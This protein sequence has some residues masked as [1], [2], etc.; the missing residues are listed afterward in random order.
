M[1]WLTC[2]WVSL[3][4]CIKPWNHILI[5]SIFPQS[6]LIFNCPFVIPKLDRDRSSPLLGVTFIN[7]NN[8]DP[9]QSWN[10]GHRT[11]RGKKALRIRFNGTHRVWQK[12][13]WVWSKFASNGWDLNY[14]SKRVLDELQNYYWYFEFIERLISQGKQHDFSLRWMNLKGRGRGKKCYKMSLF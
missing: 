1:G 8:F 13:V 9:H 14:S 11:V 3:T 4:A 5:T 7:P 10:I 6:C 2:D 12:E